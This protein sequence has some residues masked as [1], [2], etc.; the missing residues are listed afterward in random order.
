MDV[1]PGDGVHRL[2]A[3]EVHGGGDAGEVGG[4]R[5]VA[6]RGQQSGTDPVARPQEP[7]QHERPLGDEDSRGV[8]GGLL[9]APSEVRVLQPDVVGDPRVG[10]VVDP[11]RFDAPTAYP[12]LRPRKP[13]AAAPING[14]ASPRPAGMMRVPTENSSLASAS[15]SCWAAAENG[16]PQ[17]SAT[18]PATTARRRCSRLA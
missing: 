17:P 6:L 9:P 5:P 15:I 8:T 13:T 14:A 7:A 1:E 12:A 4:E 2:L 11:D 3:G 18:D 10:G 16:W